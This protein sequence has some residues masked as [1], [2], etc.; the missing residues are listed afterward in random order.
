MSRL[1]EDLITDLIPDDAGY[2]PSFINNCSLQEDASF[3]ALID[4]I[5]N[6]PINM[7]PSKKRKRGRPRKNTV[8]HTNHVTLPC[9]SA[10]LCLPKI[11]QTLSQDNGTPEC[12]ITNNGS[13]KTRV[14]G[15]DEVDGCSKDLIL[16][17]PPK[18]RKKRR[19]KV[20]SNDAIDDLPADITMNFSRWFY[21][22]LSQFRPKSQQKPEDFRPIVDRYIER[23]I[24][25][26]FEPKNYKYLTEDLS[27]PELLPLETI[28]TYDLS[29][30][31]HTKVDPDETE[32][33]SSSASTI[34]TEQSKTAN[35][36][37][38]KRKKISLSLSPKKILIDRRPM[39]RRLERNALD[40]SS[41]RRNSLIDP[42]E[43]CD[44]SDNEIPE[45]D[46][47]QESY[48][49]LAITQGES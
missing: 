26:T 42:A 20:S 33:A 19:P 46:C 1:E 30:K 10:N 18:R 41:E 14:C 43:D 27:T 13:D 22:D 32:T 37:N 28:T 7:T 23:Q 11:S 3:T 35:Q 5:M 49:V 21:G 24:N 9:E 38:A 36:I 12:P 17:K 45:I 40:D 34:E 8:S 31:E 6:H 48:E 16:A 4:S 39:L 25:F 44:G 47:D 2:L 15:V 29:L